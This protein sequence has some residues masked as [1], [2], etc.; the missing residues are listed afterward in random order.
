MPEMRH[1]NCILV[2]ERKSSTR[3]TSALYDLCTS[4]QEMATE[5]ET[6]RWGEGNASGHLG[7]VWGVDMQ[8]Q[9]T[10]HLETL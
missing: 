8:P 7:I 4:G 3:H 9:F 5:E 1:L 2:G 6:E 10:N